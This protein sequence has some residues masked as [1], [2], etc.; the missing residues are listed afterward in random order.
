V[1]EQELQ[2]L[3]NTMALVKDEVTVNVHTSPALT[4]VDMTAVVLTMMIVVV[5]EEGD[6][7][8]ET[9]TE[10]A[11]VDPP[12]GTIE[13]GISGGEID[14]KDMIGMIGM[15]IVIGRGTETETG[16]IDC[17][18]LLTSIVSVYSPSV[19]FSFGAEDDVS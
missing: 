4:M 19:I 8:T 11:I 16:G 5:V 3:G 10:T 17:E 13:T 12:D 18:K 14:T 2:P 9:E 15:M 1:E 6:M 7:M